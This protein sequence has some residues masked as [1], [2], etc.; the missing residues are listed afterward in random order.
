MPHRPSASIRSAFAISATTLA[1][2]GHKFGAPPGIGGLLVKHGVALTPRLF[3][4]HQQQAL[5]PGT[6]SVAL[7]VGMAKG[8]GNC[9]Q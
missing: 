6:E 8:A 5:R 2:S 4:G 9:V 3:G 1:F 7:A